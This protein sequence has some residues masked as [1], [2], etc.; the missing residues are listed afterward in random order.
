MP[1]IVWSKNLS[2]DVK[3]V[4]EQH[5][6][7]F[8][9]V[10]E[11]H[12]AMTVGKGKEVLGKLLAELIDYTVYHFKTEEDLFKKYGYGEYLAHKSE[13]DKLAAQASEIKKKF[14][15]GEM[16]I[17]IEVMSFLKDWLN[18]HI[19]RSDKKYTPFLNSKGVS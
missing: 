15:S 7:L 18:N 10:N 6:K 16:I 14:D 12:D 4:D 1:L 8:A 9:I 5:K 19:L 13:H 2:V 3:D 17:S 11:L